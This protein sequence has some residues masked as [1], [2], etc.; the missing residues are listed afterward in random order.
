MMTV[1][2]AMQRCAVNGVSIRHSHPGSSE[3][4]VTLIEWNAQQRWDA[5]Y[6]TDDLEDA[7]LT[8]AAMRA[9]DERKKR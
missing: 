4:M 6:Y 2:E 9:F 5:A 1:K 7:V 8:G 3:W